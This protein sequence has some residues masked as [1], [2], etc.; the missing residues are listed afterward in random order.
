MKRREL[1]QNWYTDTDLRRL[2]CSSTLALYEVLDERLLPHPPARLTHAGFC[3]FRKAL[4]DDASQ[5][6]SDEL[7][8]PGLSLK[9]RGYM[10]RPATKQLLQSQF[11]ISS[12]LETMVR[13]HR[14]IPK[15]AG[16]NGLPGNEPDA[17]TGAI[18]DDCA[19]CLSYLYRMGAVVA[20]HVNYN[21]NGWA[22]LAVAIKSRAAKTLGPLIAHSGLDPGPFQ[23]AHVL[24]KGEDTVSILRLFAVESPD[25]E[26]FHSIIKWCEQFIASDE[27]RVARELDSSA[28]YNLCKLGC[29]QIAD[30]AS[31]M[32]LQLGLAV[33]KEDGKCCWHAAAFKGHPALFSWLSDDPSVLAL[34]NSRDSRGRTPLVYAVELDREVSVSWLLYRL[35]FSQIRNEDAPTATLKAALQAA[36]L[37][38][39]EKSVRNFQRIWMH[40]AYKK[41]RHSARITTELCEMIVTDLVDCRARL[42]ASGISRHSREEEWEILCDIAKRKCQILVK[43]SPA[44]IYRGEAHLHCVL[45]AR[46]NDFEF[47][48][49]SLVDERLMNI[50]DDEAREV[51]L[52]VHFRKPT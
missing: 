35:R 39:S 47:L 14:R 43:D 50:W 21:E 27:P 31:G 51:M 9:I 25:K 52:H 34:I 29:V 1:A 4:L 10:D 26:Y 36:L 42:E 38:H 40:D 8:F 24:R 7:K 20:G 15:N 6:V 22:L 48:V 16:F 41:D 13:N 37:R 17:V 49:L 18:C 2:H 33:R 44:D 11:Q 46:K 45:R 5:V 32:N 12:T 23:S 19:P 30:W 3:S 28:Q